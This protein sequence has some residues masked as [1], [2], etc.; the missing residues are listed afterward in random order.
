MPVLDRQ[1]DGGA[2]VARAVGIPQDGGRHQRT[3]GQTDLAMT[4]PRMDAP[5]ETLAEGRDMPVLDRQDDGGADVARAVGIFPG[6]ALAERE[7]PPRAKRCWTA[8][9]ASWRRK[10]AIAPP[11]SRRW[12]NSVPRRDAELLDQQDMP[13]LDRQDDG[14]ADVARAVGIFPG[15]AVE[16]IGL[17]LATHFPKTAA[18]TNELPDRPISL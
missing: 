15:A 16:R 12:G 6:A 7:E 9:R 5:L 3:A 2:D 1:D 11:G 4:D 14:G 10:P 13:V 8:P 18:D 17:V